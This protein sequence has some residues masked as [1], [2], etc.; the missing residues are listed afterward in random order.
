M[1]RRKELGNFSKKNYLWNLIIKISIIIL[2][3]LIFGGIFTWLFQTKDIVMRVG[4]ETVRQRELDLEIKRLMPPDYDQRIQSME[5]DDRKSAED[6]LKAKAMENLMKLKSVYLYA[7][8]NNI[9]VTRKDVDVEVE[10]FIEA[11]KA[12][13]GTD[14]VDF[15]STLSDY[16]I[17]YQSFLAD[18]RQ[19]AIY[20]KVLQ[21]VRD[22]VTATDGEIIEFYQQ[23]KTYYDLPDQAKI[24]LIAVETEADANNIVEKL[25]SGE[26]FAKLAKEYSLSP[27]VELNSG[28]LG[29]VTPGELY[30]EISDNVFHPDISLN[31]PYAVQARDGFY[32]FV[33]SD[34]KGAEEKSF[35]E[36]K[37]LVKEDLL[38]NKQD[39]AVD[40]FMYQLTEEY[41][42]RITTD[43]P[44]KNLI[45]WFDSL[46]GRI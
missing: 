22:E 24:K 28:D 31:Q 10:K 35:E 30:K 46:R 23:Y 36:V 13:T 37:D 40:R 6:T 39:R 20:N 8:E 14:D 45:K 26:D 4:S 29:W 34:R 15:R 9:K 7:K 18:M 5:P 19:Q 43:N 17:R 3:V 41:E 16:G 38:K 1:A 12:S 32:V 11:L 33:V 21:P 42:F 27:D 2:P 25:Q 44:W